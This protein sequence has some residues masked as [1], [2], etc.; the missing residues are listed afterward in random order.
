MKIKI[1][2]TALCA[3][4][5]GF[6]ACDDDDDD[7]ILS[8]HP[9]QEIA[10]KEFSGVFQQI[11]TSTK[12]TTYTEGSVAFAATDTAYVCTVTAKIGS[13]AYSSVANVVKTSNGILFYNAV[14]NSIATTGF[15]G[16]IANNDEV[17]IYFERPVKTGRKTV[18][19]IFTFS[20]SKWN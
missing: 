11:N 17:T 15:N 4:A 12:D 10:G 16:S 19:N 18:N 2:I 1:L 20:N 13:A 9:E 3:F 6:S 7:P 8:T 5:L 14:S